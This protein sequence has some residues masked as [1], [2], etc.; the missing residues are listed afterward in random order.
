MLQGRSTRWVEIETFHKSQVAFTKSY[1]IQPEYHTHHLGELAHL[2][3]NKM[4]GV[5]P[6]HSCPV[7]IVIE[8][9]LFHAFL[10]LLC[11][12]C[13]QTSRPER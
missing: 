7:K 10:F 9:L 2:V 5:L 11:Y 1:S 3:Q 4:Y 13:M 6:Y 12:I 8:D